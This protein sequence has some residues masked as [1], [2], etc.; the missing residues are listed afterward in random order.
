METTMDLI[1]RR[2]RQIH[3]HSIIYYHYHTTIVNDAVFD[4]WS[5]ELVQL[6]KDYPEL[7]KQGY[8]FQLFEDWTGTTGMHLPLHDRTQ[9]LAEILLQLALDRSE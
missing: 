1:N 6:N 5:E 3:V 4:Q 9:N 7:I 2:R 8:L